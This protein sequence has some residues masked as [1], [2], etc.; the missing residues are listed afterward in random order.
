[1]G[2]RGIDLFRVLRLL[3]PEGVRVNVKSL[4]IKYKILDKGGD[5]VN[6]FMVVDSSGH[7]TAEQIAEVLEEKLHDMGIFSA[8]IQVKEVTT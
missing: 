6:I 3:K 8:S 5:N 2:D 7:L 4:V 1:V